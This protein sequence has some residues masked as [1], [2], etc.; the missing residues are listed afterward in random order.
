MFFNGKSRGITIMTMK[1]LSLVAGMALAANVGIAQAAE[2]DETAEMAESF[3]PAVEDEKPHPVKIDYDV[4]GDTLLILIDGIGLNSVKHFTFDD[5]VIDDFL[6]EW[7]EGGPVTIEKQQDSFTISVSLPPEQKTEGG[8]FGIVMSNGTIVSSEIPS[9]LLN[10]NATQPEEERRVRIWP[11]TCKVR[12]TLVSN[13][14]STAWINL[15][16]VHWPSRKR[17]CEDK[18]RSY[19][20]GSLHYSLFG[21]T[22]QQFCN[23]YKGGS[24]YIYYDTE[25]DGKIYSRDGYVYSKLRVRCKCTQWVPY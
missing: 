12:Y 8:V 7:R 3:C 16:S 20:Y 15:G 2:L 18:A 17:K 19:A 4:E 5:Q 21:I 11:R 14:Q 10:Q 24:A 22:P 6:Y 1:T 25:V 9:G 13:N 23:I